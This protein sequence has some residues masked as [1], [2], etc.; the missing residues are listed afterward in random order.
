MAIHIGHT[1]AR[2]SGRAAESTMM[3]T[4]AARG[5]PA[6]GYG[7]VSRRAVSR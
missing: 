7:I 1:V 3:N 5:A 4:M 6:C 2:L